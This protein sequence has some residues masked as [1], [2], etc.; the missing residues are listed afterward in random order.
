[1]ILA[2]PTYLELSE[3][4]SSLFMIGGLVNRLRHALEFFSIPLP[5]MLSEVAHLVHP[6]A[7]MQHP[8]IHSLDR[9][10]QS[11]TA[12]SNDQLQPPAFDTAMIEIVEQP[13]PSQLTLTLAAHESE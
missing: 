12:I 3:C 7:L 6:A 8:R 1:M 9:R 11:R 10:G 2:L 13:F 5:R 4:D